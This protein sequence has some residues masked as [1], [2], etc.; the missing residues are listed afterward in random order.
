MT[1]PV[2]EESPFRHEAADDSPG[3]LLWKL[4]TLW[5]NRVLLA[6]E[7][8]GLTQTQYAILAS[9]RWFEDH[10]Q[11]PTQ[12]LLV[13]HTKMDKMTLSKAIRRLEAAGLVSRRSAPRDARATQVRSTTRGQRVTA[14]AVEAVEDADEAFFDGLDATRLD[15]WRS[16]T[17]DLITQ[18]AP[19]TPDQ[20]RAQPRR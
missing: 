7:P 3:F 10:D 5:R 20:T 18:H 1:L 13:E 6:L 16:L 2:S 12:S 4:T 11:R 8:F 9:L 19:R 17:N 15:T 14:R